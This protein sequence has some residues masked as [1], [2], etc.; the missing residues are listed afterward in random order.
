MERKQK[1]SL[2][3][4]L[5]LIILFFIFRP[6]FYTLLISFFG[7]IITFL[8]YKK[9]KPSLNKTTLLLDSSLLFPFVVIPLILIL[10]WFL[11]P[12]LLQF[13]FNL[14]SSYQISFLE[15]L[16]NLV[17]KVVL[18]FPTFLLYTIMIFLTPLIFLKIICIINALK[19]KKYFWL[20]LLIIFSPIEILYYFLIGRDSLKKEKTKLSKK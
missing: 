2:F 16:I 1:Y 10:L 20:I 17:S 11:V 19:L 6:L 13:L 12:F 3:G 7:V 18:N 14:Y 15:Y 5:I 8:I 9:F 4:L